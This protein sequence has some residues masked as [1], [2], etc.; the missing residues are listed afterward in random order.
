MGVSPLFHEDVFVG[1]VAEI[2]ESCVT[3]VT[4]ERGRKGRK[5]KNRRTSPCCG[6]LFNLATNLADT[7]NTRGAA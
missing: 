1:M 6:L 7:T 4:V 3:A 2:G 5:T